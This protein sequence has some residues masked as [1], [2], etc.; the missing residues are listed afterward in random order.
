M[1]N[2]FG[3]LVDVAQQGFIAAHAQ[4]RE[5]LFAGVRAHGRLRENFPRQVQSLDRHT[6]VFRVSEVTWVNARRRVC[7]VVAQADFAATHG[8]QYAGVDGRAGFFD[9]VLIEVEEHDGHEM[10]LGVGAF[11]RIVGVDE[12][13]GLSDVRADRAAAEQQILQ[14]V[15]H[16]VESVVLAVVTVL[17][18]AVG[19][20][21]HFGM[22]LQVLTD[23]GQLVQ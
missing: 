22:V 17:A 23:T 7:L 9:G 11:L 6:P 18:V 1:V 14:A 4:P 5:N 15:F 2:S 13:A 10:H 8:A 19:N 20:R 16:G 3:A 12:G 21:A